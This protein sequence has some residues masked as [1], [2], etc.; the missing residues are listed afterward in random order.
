MRIDFVSLKLFVAVAEESSIAAAAAR[1]H[2]V[3]SAVSKRLAQLEESLGVELLVRHTR[4]VS[5]TAAG[6][7]L[8][9][10]AR[11]ILRSL[12]ATALEVSEYTD[13]SALHI[14][15]TANHSAMAQFLPRDLA[16]FVARQPRAHIDLVERLSADV[17][18]TVAYG[19][20]D[21]GIF[22]WPVI[23]HGVKAWP[24]R[25]DELVIAVPLDNP[26]ARRGKLDFADLADQ[27]FIAY[28]P[29]LSVS[30]A[31][32]DF[33]K[34]AWSH[35]R[36]HVANFEATCRMVEEGLGIAILPRANVDAYARQGRLACV[37]LND[38]WA[39]RRLH[40]CMRSDVEPRRGL[41]EFV[42][43]MVACAQEPAA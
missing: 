24:Y 15:L 22:C 2:L 29:N 21:V 7:T 20:A 27:K 39:S 41:V 36:M 6:E 12:E 34:S 40:I 1:E 5:L 14:R 37:Q 25:T 30:A 32:P 13:D 19:L 9:M 3:P 28:L 38:A 23:P 26:M 4:G 10:R 31:M 17:V 35:V 11:D 8:L 33:P 43:H 18:R 42:D 16:S